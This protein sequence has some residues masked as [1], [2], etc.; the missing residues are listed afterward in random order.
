MKA[1]R[2]HLGNEESPEVISSALPVYTT[3]DGTVIKKKDQTLFKMSIQA[4][5]TSQEVDLVL[6]ETESTMTKHSKG[7]EKEKE[8]ESCKISS[9]IHQNKAER[10]D[11][12]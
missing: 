7:L 3:K 2:R 4:S 6:S 11:G 12:G 1:N 9:E 5:E 10:K 8:A